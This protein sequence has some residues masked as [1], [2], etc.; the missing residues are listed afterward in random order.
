M[1]ILLSSILKEVT[2]QPE[3]KEKTLYSNEW[4]SLISKPTPGGDYIF[5]HETRCNGSIVAVL[6]Y[7]RHGLDS[8][9]YGIRLE[10]TPSWSMKPSKS[11]LTGAVDDGETPVESAVRELKEEAGITCKKEDMKSL[12][13][14]RGTKSS[15]TI[16]HLFA[17]DVAKLEKGIATGAETKY[18]KEAKMLWTWDVKDVQCPIFYTMYARLG[19]F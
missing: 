18:D 4:L 17:I 14:C 16:Y 13:T 7:F 19:L 5:S 6:P 2:S 1:S 11:S 10:I 12:G 8:W 9:K 3:N 15:D